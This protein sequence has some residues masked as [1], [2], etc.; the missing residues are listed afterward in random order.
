MSPASLPSGASQR[1][2]RADVFRAR[3]FRALSGRE[4]H[5][6]TFTELFKLDTVEIRHVEK[7]VPAV[8]GVNESESLVRQLLDRSL[9]HGNISGMVRDGEILAESD[10]DVVTYTRTQNA[11]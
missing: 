5:S 2:G 6:L 1:L 4:G 10:R 9:W 8:S 11:M 7:H 3:S